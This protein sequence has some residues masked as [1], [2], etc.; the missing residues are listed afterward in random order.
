MGPGSPGANVPVP[1]KEKGGVL[2]STGIEA[3]AHWRSLVRELIGSGDFHPASLG[4][5]AWLRNHRIWG[6][7]ALVAAGGLGL[8]WSVSG[9]LLLLALFLGAPL[10]LLSAQVAQRDQFLDPEPLGWLPLLERTFPL[11]LRAVPVQ[12]VL[13]GLWFGVFARSPWNVPATLG[14]WW[15]WFFFSSELVLGEREIVDAVLEASWGALVTPLRLPGAALR[16]ST[17]FLLSRSWEPGRDHLVRGF[18]TATFAPLAAMALV[19]LVGL[20]AVG[21]TSLRGGS[22][23][24]T[25]GS[26]LAGLAGV[27]AFD[28]STSWWTYH[29]MASLA[30]QEIGELPDPDGRQGELGSRRARELSLPEGRDENPP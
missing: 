5:R 29:Y 28:A 7:R 18:V 19:G 26:S 10:W 15:W 27:L 4:R 30:T 9:G 21:F 1:C 13:L 24:W 6:G 11:L 23:A 25:V 3:S 16:W 12:V 8:L 22:L 2:D 17:T 20:F 14:I